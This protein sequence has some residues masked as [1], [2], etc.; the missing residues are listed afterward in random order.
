MGHDGGATA[1]EKAAAAGAW[2]LN[3]VLVLRKGSSDSDVE[4]MRRATR[5]CCVILYN[6]VYDRLSES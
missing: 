4:Q 5:M 1:G 6:I 2:R 3:G